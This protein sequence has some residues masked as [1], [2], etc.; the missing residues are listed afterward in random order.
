MTEEGR[1]LRLPGTH[2][3][4]ASALF[5]NVVQLELP[6]PDG[7]ARRTIAVRKARQSAHLEGARPFSITDRGIV[8]EEAAP[9]AAGTEVGR[10]K[11]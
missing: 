6:R 3:S 1:R 8:V 10:R 2:S 7:K 9:Q 4:V 11:G 5:D